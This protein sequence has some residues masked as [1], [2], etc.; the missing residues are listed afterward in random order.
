M[1]YFIYKKTQ[2]IY[3]LQKLI[4]LLSLFNYFDYKAYFR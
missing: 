3:F 1:E 2:I 4:N